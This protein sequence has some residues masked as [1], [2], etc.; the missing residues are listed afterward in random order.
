[1][2]IKLY[3]I[4]YE[5]IDQVKE[6]MQGLLDPITRE[7]VIGHARV[8][9]VFKV[10]KGYVGGSLT[11]A[12]PGPVKQPLTGWL[13]LVELLPAGTEGSPV[14]RVLMRNLLSEP[15]PPH[16]TEPMGQ[17]WRPMNVPEGADPERLQLLGWVSDAKGRVLALAQS[18]CDDAD[19]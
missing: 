10:N 18:S 19:R 8:K 12:A 6:A 1:M 4:I 2:Q 13:A 3:S 15:I 14:P 9:Q 5:L 16:A 7:K 17:L 11:F